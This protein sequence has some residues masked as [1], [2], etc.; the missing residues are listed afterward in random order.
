MTNPFYSLARSRKFLLA[1]LA[2][3]QALVLNY[4]SI[5]EEI[6]QAIMLVLMVLIGSIALEDAAEKLHD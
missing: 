1:V 5:P 2:L 6:W 4:L 3:I